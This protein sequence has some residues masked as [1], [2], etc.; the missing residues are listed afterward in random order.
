MCV[1]M[2]ILIIN[3]NLKLTASSRHSHVLVACVRT[4]KH[5]PCVKAYP[6]LYFHQSSVLSGKFKEFNQL[7][8]HAI[9]L[10]TSGMSTVNAMW[11]Y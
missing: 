9:N 7:T 3:T 4:Q 5:D 6:S 10:L 2:Y 11:A 8:I 1:H